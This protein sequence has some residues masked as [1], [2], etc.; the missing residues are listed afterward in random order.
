MGMRANSNGMNANERFS[1]VCEKDSHANERISRVYDK[2]LRANEAAV[3][4]INAN[5]G[6]WH[7]AQLQYGRGGTHFKPNM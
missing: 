2:D 4:Y 7:F 5:K 3:S 6:F 1:R